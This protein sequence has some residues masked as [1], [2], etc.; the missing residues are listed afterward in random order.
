MP[1][2]TPEQRLAEAEQYNHKRYRY[3]FSLAILLM[4]FSWFLCL[5]V[6]RPSY[7]IFAIIV[8]IA[9]WYYPWRYH[10]KVQAIR[11]DLKDLALKT[12][13]TSVY[14]TS[15]S[16]INRLEPYY[17]LHTDDRIDFEIEQELYKILKE[18]QQIEITYFVHSKI[19]VALRFK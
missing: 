8:T 1:K 14:S 11:K 13:E 2:Q 16:N 5:S 10:K 18:G 4:F 7:W 6:Q 17:Y 12:L 9:I 15:I 3:Y 19:I